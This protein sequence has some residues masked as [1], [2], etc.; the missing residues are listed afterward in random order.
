MRL[1]SGGRGAAGDL[2]LHG[3]DGGVE[4]VDIGD[5][6]PVLLRNNP[7]RGG[8]GN[9][10]ALPESVVGVDLSGEKAGRVHDEGHVQLVRLEEL[11]SEVVEVFLRGNR[12]LRSK[13]GPAELLGD[14][15]RDLVLQIASCNRSVAA[16][17]VHL[18]G[19]VVADDGNLIALG[20]GM[21]DGI[22]VGAGG[23]LEI[24]ELEDGDLKLP[25]VLGGAEDCAWAGTQVAR[26]NRRAAAR[27]IRFI[28]VRRI[29]FIFLF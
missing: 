5:L 18:E 21:H 13:D 16:P 24:F 7:D 22:G 29:G 26:A 9:T 3:V 17:D 14:L 23:A 1:R 15:G 27:A 10:D 6:D 28:E 20:G 12:H 8:L 2:G 11:L 19:E 4:L 25:P